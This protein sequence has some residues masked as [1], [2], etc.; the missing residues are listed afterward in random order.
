MCTSDITFTA[1]SFLFV[2]YLIFVFFIGMTIYEFKI[3]TKYLFTLVINR[4][5]YMQV[6]MNM[7]IV[8][9]PK[10]LYVAKCC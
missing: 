4:N 9:K 2:G 10:N 5:P 8:F 3:P 7:S 6:S 1:K